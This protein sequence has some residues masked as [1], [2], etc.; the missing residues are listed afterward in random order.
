MAKPP[1][2]LKPSL[3]RGQGPMLRSLLKQMDVLIESN[4][5]QNEEFHRLKEEL[6]G[7]RREFTLTM[8]SLADLPFVSGVLH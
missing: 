2:K 1:S 3:A 6:E 8:E 7:L 5:K 4:R